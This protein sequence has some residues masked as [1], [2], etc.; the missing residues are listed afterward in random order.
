MC[1]ISHIHIFFGNF[2][3]ASNVGI[4]ELKDSFIPQKSD[5]GF[6]PVET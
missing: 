1:S 3:I 6:V 4:M 5:Y 2:A